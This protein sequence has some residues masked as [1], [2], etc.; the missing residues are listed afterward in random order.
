LQHV[1]QLHTWSVMRVCVC[2]RCREKEGVN[3]PQSRTTR[4]TGAPQTNRVDLQYLLHH[5]DYLVAYMRDTLCAKVKG[6][7]VCLMEQYLE[8]Y[9]QKNAPEHEG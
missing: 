3:P 8:D 7:V 4:R 2:V 5:A 1:G 9:L 6:E